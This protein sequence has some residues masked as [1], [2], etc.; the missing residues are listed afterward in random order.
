MRLK[1]DEPVY[2]AEEI[3]RKLS[4]FTLWRDYYFTAL[5]RSA[6]AGSSKW[7]RKMGEMCGLAQKGV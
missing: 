4:I 3:S 2:L 5:I 7:N 6:V 1:D